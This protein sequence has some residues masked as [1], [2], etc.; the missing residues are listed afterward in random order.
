MK[1]MNFVF[2]MM[3]CVLKMMILMQISRGGAALPGCGGRGQGGDGG[4][5]S[6]CGAALNEVYLYIYVDLILYMYIYM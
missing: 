6:G 4:G 3:D 1:S 2:K 5:C